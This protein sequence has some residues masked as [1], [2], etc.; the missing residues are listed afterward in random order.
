M[1]CWMESEMCEGRGKMYEVRR[2]R[3][4][5]RCKRYDV[6]RM[7]DEVGGESNKKGM[8]LDKSHPFLVIIM[9]TYSYR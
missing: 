1:R 2:K 8:R 9:L 4:D 7:K 5:V 6:R 3:Y